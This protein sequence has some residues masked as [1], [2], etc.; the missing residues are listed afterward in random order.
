MSKDT[1]TPFHV[2]QIQDKVRIKSGEFKGQKGVV[3]AISEPNIEVQLLNGPQIA[4][5]PSDITN[6]SLAARKAWQ[7]MRERK[8]N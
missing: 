5:A 6:Y 4:V 1:A 7:T 3:Q 2:H 8:K